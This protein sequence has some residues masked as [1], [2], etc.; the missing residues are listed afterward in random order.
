MNSLNK[1]LQQATKGLWGK[2]KLEI[3]EE[4]TAHILERAYKH[5]ISGIPHETAVIRAIEELGDPKTIR[6]GMIGV[7]TMPNVFKISGVLTV[8]AAGAIAMLSVS[9]AQIIGTTRMPIAECADTNLPYVTLQVPNSTT[10]FKFS[11]S[12]NLLWLNC[13]S[14]CK[15]LEPLK[16]EFVE[17]KRLEPWMPKAQRWLLNFPEGGSIYLEQK[18]EINVVGPDWES[19]KV[20]YLPGLIQSQDFVEGLV[21]LNVPFTMSGWNN[22]TV[23]VGKLRFQIGSDTTN[24]NG[25]VWYTSILGEKLKT[26]LPTWRNEYVLT[27]AP[28]NTAVTFRNYTHKIQTEL[29]ENQIVVVLNRAIPPTTKDENNRQILPFS[30]LARAYIATVGKNGILEYPSEAKTL[31]FMNK[32][33]GLR[34]TKTDG[35]GDIVVL[36]F[37]HQMNMG[38][39]TF[40][41]IPSSKLS[42]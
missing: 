8:I 36:K 35:A 11:C 22:P 5:E 15:I 18:Q 14:L 12:S 40:A 3:H 19:I 32:V 28:N 10:E 2:K 39:E 25:S 33:Q 1:Y 21:K 29:P 42:K 13:E 41:V 27:D 17:G 24:I 31:R 6:T 7:H 30:G 9:S 23:R 26:L 34:Q 20:S 38:K 37:T 4:L 16:V